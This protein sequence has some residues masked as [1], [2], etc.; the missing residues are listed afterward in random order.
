[1]FKD[2]KAD[3]RPAVPFIRRI[4]KVL[5]PGLITGASDDDPSGI[6]TYSQ[7]G[8][9]F[10]Y[11]PTWTLVFSYP[12]MVAIQIISA[13]L[14]RTTGKGIAG[15]L[16]KWYPPWLLYAS[17]SL[18][19]VANTINVGAD[20]GAMADTVRVLV[21]GPQLAYVLFFGCVCVAMQVYIPYKRYV[22]VLRW[23][24]L[25]LLAYIAT[26]F[27]VHVNFHSLASSIFI[28]HISFE[29][30]YLT[31]IVAIFGT[32]ISPYLFFWQA[33]EEVEDIRA[34]SERK[35]LVQAPEQKQDAQFRIE[36]DT[37]A[38]MALSNIVALAIMVTAAATLHASGLTNIQTSAQAAE[39]LR[40]AAGVF[41]GTIFALGVIGTGLLAVPVLA[42][43]AAYAVGESLR[44]PTGLDREPRQAKAFYATIAGATAIG[45]AL[46]FSP[47]GPIQALYWSA[48]I[49]GV[50]AVPI[51]TVM[52]L[53]SSNT[54]IMGN[55]P[56]GPRLKFFGWLSTIVM[57]FTAAAMILTAV[58]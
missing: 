24:T 57:G 38:G 1:M 45:V 29:T 52:I 43:S 35:P 8:A 30:N 31:A 42:G 27:F 56:I 14:G 32:T 40:P 47:V 37:F 36:V 6:A 5:G 18:L 51:M 39:A 4:P 16:R 12:L 53:M 20:I 9:Q 28:P 44:W 26:L 3:G 48:V 22:N 21:G 41:A 58:L 11:I 46:N 50:V 15:N 7:T 54:R 10:G 33:S 19:L 23:L 25:A 34:I 2:A 17:V 13:S 55:A 49:N